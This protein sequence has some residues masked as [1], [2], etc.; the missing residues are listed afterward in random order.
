M[1]G[2]T[3][4]LNNNMITWKQKEIQNIIC[5]YRDKKKSLN[6][7]GQQYKVSKNSIKRLLVKNNITIR[8]A[9]EIR[10]KKFSD[11]QTKYVI[12]LYTNNISIKSIS[13][14]FGVDSSVI[15]RMLIENNICIRDDSE[16]QI[17]YD[18]KDSYFDS[19]DTEDKA[20]WLG[21]I[22]ADGCVFGNRLKITLSEKDKNHLY[23]FRACINSTHPIKN[24]EVNLNTNKYKGI[25]FVVNNRKMIKKL[26]SYGVIPNKHDLVDVPQIDKQFLRHY[27]RGI[28]DGDGCL[29]YSN[30]SWCCYLAGNNNILS[31]FAEFV[32]SNT[33]CKAN[34]RRFKKYKDYHT[35]TYVFSTSGN[36]IVPQIA[37]LLYKD[38]TVYLDRKYNIYLEMLSY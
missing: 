36:I 5:L 31:K 30:Y 11:K 34:V 16:C 14:E 18:I 19:I 3:K 15:K 22:T 33:D 28:F 29:S 20:Y 24:I 1:Y 27:Y 35:Q 17:K 7:I 13:E 12:E 2:Y 38:S 32:K 37:S 8:E 10:R 9:N 21:F 4:E 6:K 25:E 23:K 26:N